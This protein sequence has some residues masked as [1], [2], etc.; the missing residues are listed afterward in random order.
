MTMTKPDVCEK[1][2]QKL[3][4]GAETFSYKSKIICKECHDGLQPKGNY[5]PRLNEQQ[6]KIILE[7][8]LSKFEELLKIKKIQVVRNKEKYWENFFLTV[9]KFLHPEP[10]NKCKVG[11][12]RYWNWNSDHPLETFKYDCRERI[13][14]IKDILK[15][16]FSKTSENEGL[17]PVGRSV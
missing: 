7:L 14:E 11:T 5:R 6:R 2:Y 4:K 16:G 15:N 10:L 12:W 13:K 1:C 9:D 3:P 8:F 17:E